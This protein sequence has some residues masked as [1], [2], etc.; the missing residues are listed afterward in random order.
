MFTFLIN[1]ILKDARKIVLDFSEIKKGEK[2]LDIGCGNGDQLFYFLKKDIECFGIDINKKAIKLADK[3]RKKHKFHNIF[4]QVAEASFLPFEDDFFDCCIISLLLHE[5]KREKIDKIV[6]EAKRV[7][8]KTGCL[9]FIDFTSP[10]PGNF[11][12]FLIQKIEFFV[13]REN[14]KNFKDYLREGGIESVIRR[15]DLREAERKKIKKGNITIIKA[16]K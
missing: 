1:S 11:I 15:N 6:F 9:I 4:F 3:K 2:L 12:S 10:L 13:G 7:T 16:G 8:K 14:Y 5:N